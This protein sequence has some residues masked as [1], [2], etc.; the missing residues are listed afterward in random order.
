MF[1]FAL[2]YASVVIIPGPGIMTVITQA[3]RLSRSRIF[4]LIAGFVVGDLIWFFAALLGLSAAL[5]ATP[6]LLTPIQILGAGYLILLSVR[7]WK[8]GISLKPVV[9]AKS[10]GSSSHTLFFGSLLLTLSNPK[11]L[12]FY[13]A[14]LPIALDT[15]A[16]SALQVFQVI[17]IIVTVLSVI[18]VLYALAGSYLEKYL[19]GKPVEVW[20]YRCFSLLIFLLSI[21]MLY[22]AIS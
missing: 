2:I 6:M 19:S 13:V 10:A 7:L 5:R 3:G 16:L 4:F 17:A 15:Q 11:V 21:S 20:L 22:E 18:K 1:M 12:I 8:E 9:G 14:I